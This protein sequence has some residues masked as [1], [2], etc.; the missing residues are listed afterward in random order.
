[1]R[2]DGWRQSAT[3]AKPWQRQFRRPVEASRPAER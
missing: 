1:L 2:N 3:G